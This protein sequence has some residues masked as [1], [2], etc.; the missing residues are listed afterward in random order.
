MSF[1]E[2]ALAALVKTEGAIEAQKKSKGGPLKNQKI[3]L[4]KCV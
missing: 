1:L 4:S 2:I 3:F